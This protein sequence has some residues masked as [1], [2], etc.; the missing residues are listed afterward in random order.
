MI[1]H[2]KNDDQRRADLE[3][4]GILR[5]GRGEVPKEIIETPP[6]LLPK[7]VSALALLLQEREEGR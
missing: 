2:E 1:S 3:R 7:G 5:V 6:P 4:R